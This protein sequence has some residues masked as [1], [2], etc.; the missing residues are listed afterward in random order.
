MIRQ[1]IQIILLTGA[2]VAG[3]VPM[4]LAQDSDSPPSSTGVVA[5]ITA[6]DAKTGLAT[7]QTEAGEVFELPKWRLWKVG[8]KVLC[9]RIDV[10]RPRF[11]RCQP[12]Q[13]HAAGGAAAR[14]EPH[15][16][17]K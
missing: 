5:T 16:S 1:F 13:V 11:E 15:I 14:R 7:L 12:W 10:L 3:F 4:T 2:M 17:S 6:L 8:D 9:D